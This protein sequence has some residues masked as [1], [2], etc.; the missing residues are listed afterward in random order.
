[1]SPSAC[2]LRSREVRWGSHGGSGPVDEVTTLV[3]ALLRLEAGMPDDPMLAEVRAKLKHILPGRLRRRAT[4]TA[5]ATENHR[6]P[7]SPSLWP[8]FGKIADAVASASRL[9]FAYQDKDDR[10][11]VQL[12]EP[13]RHV[14]REQQ[15][16]LVAYDRQ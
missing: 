7:T 8:Q 3:T 14:F 4:A 9:S 5:M 2:G 13:F 6:V 15:W 16:D 12:V 1:M 11:S 10:P